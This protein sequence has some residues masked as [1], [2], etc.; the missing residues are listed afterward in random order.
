MD[1]K[2]PAASLRVSLDDP[3]TNRLHSDLPKSL[4]IDQTHEL[5]TYLDHIYWWLN[6]SH[7]LHVY[8][9]RQIWMTQGWHRWHFHVGWFTD[10]KQPSEAEQALD[11]RSLSPQLGGCH[12]GCVCGG[13]FDL[14]YYIPYANHGGGIFTYKTGWF[15]TRVDG[16]EISLIHHSS[17]S[18]KWG[19]HHGD[20]GSLSTSTSYHGSIWTLNINVVHPKTL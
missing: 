20:L 2:N 19:Q 9:C 6:I 5:I 18:S 4:R 12:S 3:T 7:V 10:K 8:I 17:P 14:I 16:E 13:S 11:R 1:D 15:W